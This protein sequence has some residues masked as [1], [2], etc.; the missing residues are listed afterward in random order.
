[1]TIAEARA[2][3]PGIAIHRHAETGCDFAFALTLPP[4]VSVMIERGIVVRVDVD[5]NSTATAEGARVGDSEEG[6]RS[7]YRGR[8]ST[9]PHKY[10]DGHYLTVT[11]VSRTDS[12][13]RIIF[14]TDSGRVT[15][16]RAG[17]LPQ[18]EYVEG[19]S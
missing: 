13:L 4:G 14:E 9:T 15:G 19:C 17:Q 2:A 1:M 18:V 12:L 7:F 6:V 3:V 8:I 16:Y 10:T 11:P 5:S